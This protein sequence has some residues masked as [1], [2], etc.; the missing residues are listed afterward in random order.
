MSSGLARQR[1]ATL[2]FYST[3]LLLAYLVYLLFSPFLTSLAW[4]A[5]LA[6][7]FHSPYRHLEVRWGRAGAAA[8][9]TAVVTLVIVVPVVLLTMAFIQEAALAINSVDVSVQTEGFARLQRI[10]MRMQASRLGANLGNLEDVVRQGTAWTAGLVAGQVGDVL[11]NL[12]AIIVDLVVM[13]FALFFFFRDGDAIMAAL[14]QALPFESEQSERM[15]AEAGELIQASV[16]AGFIVAALQGALGGIMFALLGLG[17]PVFWGVVMAF[18]ALLPVGAGIVWLPAATWLLFTGSV[19]RGVTLLLAAAGIV[20]LVDNFLRPLLLSGR[21]Q[22]N[23]L[24]V[25]VSLL[26]GISAFGFLG[27]V[28]GPVIMATTIGMFDAYTRERRTAP[29]RVRGLTHTAREEQ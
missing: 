5:I 13:L 2:L 8:A 15:I 9:S 19:A 1:I 25:F 21:T 22:L 24:L 26:G 6:A 12:V 27:L 23:G 20:V 14:R 4:A 18:S 11:R 16:I 3:V 17:A 7:L 10:W 28:L 29:R